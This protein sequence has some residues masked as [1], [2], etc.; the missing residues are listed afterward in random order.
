MKTL[1]RAKLASGISVDTA[2]VLFV[3]KSEPGVLGGL[4]SCAIRMFECLRRN[5]Y[6]AYWMHEDAPIVEY[7]LTRII[8]RLQI[9]EI[10]LDKS[11]AY[12]NIR[13]IN[14][15]ASLKNHNRVIFIC[16]FDIML[17]YI[18]EKVKNKFGNIIV[19]N[20]FYALH[21]YY[22]ICRDTYSKSTAIRRLY[23]RLCKHNVTKINDNRNIIYM[24]KMCADYVNKHYRL[25]YGTNDQSILRLGFSVL[26]FDEAKIWGKT[27]RTT[28]TILTISRFDFPF[29][30]YLLGLIDEFA[31]IVEKYPNA[32]L[33]IIGNGLGAEELLSKIR[34]QNDSVKNAIKLQGK[35]EYFRLKQYFDDANI[36]IGMGTTL[37]DAVNCGVPSI[38]VDAYKYECNCVGFFHDNID[39]LAG[40][41]SNIIVSAHTLI[42]KVINMSRAEYITLCKAAHQKFE[43]TYNIDN[44]LPNFLSKIVI[45]NRAIFRK[46]ELRFIFLFEA[47][48]VMVNRVL[49][50]AVR[51]YR[52]IKTYLKSSYPSL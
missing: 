8:D 51:C 19:D 9:E 47:T 45:R 36:F 49:T 12:S 30:G 1:L 31:K 34:I 28:F 52:E 40:M 32:R 20:Y 39:K 17:Y 18:I 2:V 50:H 43:M 42:E 24:D 38:V 6:A 44:I 35:I 13:L 37:L 48:T 5:G 11:I 15:P 41:G 29:K 27:I 7:S 16:L 22:G 26:P 4:D 25:G 14:V 46:S 21:P 10:V 3:P 23:Y 33:S